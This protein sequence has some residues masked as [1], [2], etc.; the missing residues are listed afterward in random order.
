MAEPRLESITSLP[1]IAWAPPRPGLH[2]YAG[3]VTT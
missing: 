1:G 2:E 3:R